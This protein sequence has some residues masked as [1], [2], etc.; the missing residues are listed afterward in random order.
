MTERSSFRER[1]AACLYLV[2]N[3]MTEH[4]VR[5]QGA[6]KRKSAVHQ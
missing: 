5:L 2:P 6:G 1:I 4:P 3:R